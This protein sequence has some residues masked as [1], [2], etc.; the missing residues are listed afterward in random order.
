MMASFSEKRMHGGEK[1]IRGGEKLIRGGEKLIHGGDKLIHGG[2]KLINGGAIQ[3]LVNRHTCLLTFSH[4]R[5]N[6]ETK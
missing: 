6:N 1:L 5:L 2:D 4:F 3:Y